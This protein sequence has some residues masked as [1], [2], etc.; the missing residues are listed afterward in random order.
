MSLDVNQNKD[1][2]IKKEA[3]QYFVDAYLGDTPR[4]HP[5]GS[6]LHGSLKGFPPLLVHVDKNELMYGD[7]KKLIAKAKKQ[8]VKVESY[9]TD[10]M[11]HVHHLYARY[12][13]EA[14]DAIKNIGDFI[15]KYF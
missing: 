9:M 14:R 11:W 4:N 7:S 3:L 8:G 6:P 2:F 13:P 10:N 12:V 5:I 1:F 15:Q